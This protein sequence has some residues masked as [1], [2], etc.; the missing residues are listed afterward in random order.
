MNV[1]SICRDYSSSAV[2]HVQCCSIFVQWHMSVMWN[3]CMPVVM[4]TLF[5]AFSSYEVDILK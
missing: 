1:W 2:G 4:V 5:I 3:V